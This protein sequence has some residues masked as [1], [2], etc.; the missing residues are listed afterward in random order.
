MVRTQARVENNSRLLQHPP[1]LLGLLGCP[2]PPV[3]S[4][5]AVGAQEGAVMGA[6]EGAAVA[7]QEAWPGTTPGPWQFKHSRGHRIIE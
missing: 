3:H 5:A 6:Q 7:V 1:I 4:G 2:L